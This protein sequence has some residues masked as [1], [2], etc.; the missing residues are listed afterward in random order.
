MRSKP[1]K[2]P[3]WLAGVDGCRAGWVAAFVR[4]DG[5]DVRVRNIQHFA[6]VLTALEAPVIVAVDIP[7]GLPECIGPAG[8]GPERANGRRTML[9]SV[10][11]WC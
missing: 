10:R 6:D 9:L 2:D 8:R 11:I 7:I 5:D 4:P 3:V 1:W